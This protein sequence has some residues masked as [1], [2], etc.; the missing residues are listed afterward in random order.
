MVILDQDYIVSNMRAFK[1]RLK[2]VDLRRKAGL[3]QRQL[4]EKL[5]VTVDTIANWER[6]RVNLWHI[7]I[8]VKLCEIFECSHK[9]L[10]EFEKVELVP[11]F[12]LEEIRRS[13]G[14]S[15]HVKS[16]V[17]NTKRAE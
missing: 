5:G 16:S 8:F 15:S 2:I 13:L 14:T 11:E 9:E 7:E 3:T 6:G 10:V 17:D 4:A 12:D 1:P